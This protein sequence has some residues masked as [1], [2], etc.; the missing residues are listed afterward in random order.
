MSDDIL[1]IGIMPVDIFHLG[2]VRACDHGCRD[3]SRLQL[4]HELHHSGNRRI[5]HVLLKFIQ[6]FDDMLLQFRLSLEVSIQDMGQCL[7]FAQSADFADIAVLFAN[8]VPEHGV[9]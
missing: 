5:R 6:F 1:E 2:L 9:L 4:F 3:G 7:S 8:V